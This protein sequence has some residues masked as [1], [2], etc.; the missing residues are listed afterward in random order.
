MYLCTITLFYNITR[1][2]AVQFELDIHLCIYVPSLYITKF[3]VGLQLDI[4]VHLYVN[5]PLLST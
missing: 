1:T 5:V 3:T 2:V 4:D